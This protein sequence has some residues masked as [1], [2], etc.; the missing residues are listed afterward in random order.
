MT[1]T[2]IINEKS[3]EIHL[4]E[5]LIFLDDRG[6]RNSLNECLVADIDSLNIYMDELYFMDSAGLGML[7]IARNECKKINIPLTLYNPSGDVKTLLQ[8]TKSYDKFNIVD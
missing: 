4:K 7:I 8:M 1:I 3:A 6:F 5:K 2:K